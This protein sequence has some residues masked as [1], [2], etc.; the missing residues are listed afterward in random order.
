M[1]I[2]GKPLEEI[3]EALDKVSIHTV[4]KYITK[5]SKKVGGQI[6]KERLIND[7]QNMWEQGF[8]KSEIEKELGVNWITVSKHLPKGHIQIR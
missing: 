1:Y 7:A 5:E 3:A 4:S 2:Q 6:R 8:S